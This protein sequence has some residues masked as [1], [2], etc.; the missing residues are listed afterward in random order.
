MEKV[1]YWKILF[2]TLD[3]SSSLPGLCDE[4]ILEAIANDDRVTLL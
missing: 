4:I 1:S 2:E 3:E